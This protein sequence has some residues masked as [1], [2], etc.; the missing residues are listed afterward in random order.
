MIC[1]RI[2]D[3]CFFIFQAIYHVDI[4]VNNCQ[5]ACYFV[6][7]SYVIFFCKWFLQSA[8]LALDTSVLDSDQVE[9]LI[10]FCPTNEEIEMLKVLLIAIFAF[11]DM[12]LRLSLSI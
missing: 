11:H 3:S 5:S 2:L 10:K 4:L 8:I 9:N 7:F 6:M 1:V 12:L